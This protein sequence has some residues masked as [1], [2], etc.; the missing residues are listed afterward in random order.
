MNDRFTETA[1]IPQSVIVILPKWVPII[2][3]QKTWLMQNQ[4]AQYVS[5]HFR[6]QTT[7]NEESIYL[8]DNIQMTYEIFD[9]VKTKYMVSG[10]EISAEQYFENYQGNN[11]VEVINE[12]EYVTYTLF[13]DDALEKFIWDVRIKSEKGRLVARYVVEHEGLTLI[14]SELI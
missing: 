7:N 9:Q 3:L 13:K 4:S 1:N 5:L 10:E 12:K 8:Y 6:D 11:Q 14:D 2:L